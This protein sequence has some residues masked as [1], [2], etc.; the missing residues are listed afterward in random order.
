MIL[1]QARSCQEKTL[2]PDAKCNKDRQY[3]NLS[4][5]ERRLG[6]RR[7]QRLKKRQLLE[8]L[9]NRNEYIEIESRPRHLLGIK[10]GQCLSLLGEPITRARDT[11][12]A[13][14]SS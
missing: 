14:A 7:R 9:Y 6:L 10:T 8:R 11:A 1:T 4:D 12:F 2:R 5:N 13:K 3:D